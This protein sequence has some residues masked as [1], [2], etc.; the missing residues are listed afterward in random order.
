MSHL[1]KVKPLKVITPLLLTI[2]ISACGGSSDSSDIAITPEPPNTPSTPTSTNEDQFG[3]WLTDLSDNFIIPAYQDL[4][5]KAQV[6]SVQ[7]AGFCS[8]TNA[9]NTDLQIV[10]QS[11]LDL[12]LSW[13]SIQWLKVGPVLDQS[14]IFRIE[15]WPD[16]ND[17]VARGLETLLAEPLTLT[18]DIVSG[19]N[20]GGQGISA[21]EVLLFTTITQESLL[22]ASNKN[23]RCEAVQAI[24]SNLLNISTE[25]SNEWKSTD[26][27]YVA[28]LKNG[29]GD[30]T[31]KKDAVEELITNFL[32]S[33]ERVKDEKLLEP[34]EAEDVTITEFS[35]SDASISSIKANVKA[36][37]KIYTANDG[38]GFDDILTTHFSQSAISSDIDAKILAIMTALDA[39][40]SSKSYAQL[41][42][43]DS[44]RI[45]ISEVVQKIRE[46][47]DVITT[48]FVQATDINIGFNSNDG[49]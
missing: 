29:T 9:A 23:K 16:S 33:I 24:S 21:L 44:S 43:D 49:D 31:N 25:I 13:Q 15:F 32:E 7:S 28:S 37:S 38:H 8:L 18:A 22:S 12:N 48:D 4:Q 19:V 45:L 6:L 5:E 1:T 35:L 10:Q 41:L 3:L 39:L 47:R 30:F 36:F 2:I 46:L 34:W 40:D 20:V 14:R 11:W 17:A 26:G 42:S 27:N